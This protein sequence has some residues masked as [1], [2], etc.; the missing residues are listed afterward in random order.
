MKEVRPTTGI[1][2]QALFNILGD[3]RGAG[4]LDLFSGSGRIA[5]EACRRGASPVISVELVKSRSKEI[6]GKNSYDFHTHLCMDVRKALSWISRRKIS[7]DFVFAD[8]P[9]GD[10]WGETLPKLLSLRREVVKENGLIVIEHSREE[11][12]MPVEPWVIRDERI[13]GRS[14]LSFLSRLLDRTEEDVR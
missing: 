4:F 13:Y 8:P 2:L 11:P 10:G 12:I 7:F 5:M 6:W 9:Y 14:V 3:I 1:V